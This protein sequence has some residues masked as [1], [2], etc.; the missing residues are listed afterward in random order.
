MK[1]LLVVCFLIS[2]IAVGCGSK[3][4]D[5]TIE[6]C[7]M[8]FV[9]QFGTDYK[10]LGDSLYTKTIYKGT[11]DGAVGISF[12]DKE[13][14]SNFTSNVYEGTNFKVY[15][16]M[17]GTEWKYFYEFADD[18]SLASDLVKST[19][20]YNYS[21]VSYLKSI[22]EDLAKVEACNQYIGKSFDVS[23]ETNAERD[24]IKPKTISFGDTFTFDGYEL[25]F[26]D[27]TWNKVDNR[28]SDLN[29]QS[30]AMVSVKV[31]N[32]NTA[33]GKINMFYYTVY[34]PSGSRVETVN[35]YF[36][37]TLAY[38]SELRSGAEGTFNFP[39]LY[40]GDGLYSIEFDNYSSFREV[41][42]NIT[43]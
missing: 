11:D 5:Y 40:L 36:K 27:I 41:Q 7:E 39:I 3:T 8:A 37:N 10:D 28:Y 26:G 14:R 18:N 38:D 42:L 34:G 2:G 16:K 21:P 32:T 20:A 9:E 23:D 43:K 19:K 4:K 13:F 6:E 31:K 35:A 30:V 33:T 15:G 22:Y 17:D 12:K 25:T 24:N 1:K 29:G